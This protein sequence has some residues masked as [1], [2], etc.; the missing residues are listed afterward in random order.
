MIPPPS[1]F[2]AVFSGK[3][4]D[5]TSWVGAGNN[6]KVLGLWYAPAATLH[7]DG[8]MDFVDFMDEVDGL[9]V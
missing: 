7:H 1:R 3:R 9:G 8:L 4:N 5:I 2:F 6:L